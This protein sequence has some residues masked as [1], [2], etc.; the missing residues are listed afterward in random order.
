MWK[1]SGSACADL[2]KS[3]RF[4]PLRLA[5]HCSV[6]FSPSWLFR[7]PDKKTIILL[8]TLKRQQQ[9]QWIIL[10]LPPLSKTN[11]SWGP[12]CNPEGQIRMAWDST[13]GVRAMTEPCGVPSPFPHRWNFGFPQVLLI[14]ERFSFLG[15]L[16]HNTHCKLLALSCWELGIC[17]HS[18]SFLNVHLLPSHGLGKASPGSMCQATSTGRRQVWPVWLQKLSVLSIAWRQPMQLATLHSCFIFF[19]TLKHWEV[20]NDSEI[21]MFWRHST[22]KVDKFG[23]FLFWNSH[24]LLLLIFS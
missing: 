13:A 2:P 19:L 1:G 7:K 23:L 3:G 20:K 14:S 18:Y 16:S 24:D 21:S 5:S 9:N 8:C 10:P 17:P 12:F 15:S 4:S 11:P 22:Q 6:S